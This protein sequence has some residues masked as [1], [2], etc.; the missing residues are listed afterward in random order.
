MAPDC[1]KVNRR[2]AEKISEKRKEPNASA[3]NYKEQRLDLSKAEAE[4][5]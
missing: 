3:K 1:T 4:P 5:R 2:L